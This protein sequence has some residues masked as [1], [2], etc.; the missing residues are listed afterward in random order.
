MDVRVL[1]PHDGAVFG[2]WYAVVTASHRDLWSGDPGPA[3]AEMRAEAL[4]DDDVERT[5]TLAAYD[6]DALVGAARTFAPLRDNTHLLVAEVWVPPER[7]RRG[8]GTALVRAV[9]CAA[10]EDGRTTVL[11]AQE[12]PTRLALRS[13]GRAFA[14][15]R[16]YACAQQEVMRDLA[17]PADPARLGPLEEAC[18]EKAGGYD[19][20]TW[21][22]HCP[23]EYTDDRA[24]LGRRMSTDIPLGDLAFHEEDWDASRVRL[25]EARARDEGRLLLGT[26][27]VHDGRMVAFTELQVPRDRPEKA[28]QWD[29][30]VLTEHRGHRLGTLVKIENLR[31]LAAVSPATRRVSTQNAEVNGP[32]ITV[33]EALGCT[34]VGT[35]TEWQKHL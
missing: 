14:E 13:P 10:R 32:M 1:D 34:V 20:V 6:E 22:E 28:Y 5:E 24:Y 23:D 27:A 33:N 7:R 25:L 31:R 4:A 26:G 16:G 18:R 29:T 3:Q 2:D 21:S 12:E 17:L 8:A 30:L 11:A 9:E 15:A 35:V 19:V